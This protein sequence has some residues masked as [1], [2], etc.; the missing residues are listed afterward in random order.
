MSTQ[1][2]GPMVRRMVKEPTFSRKQERNLSVPLRTAR[3]PRASGS[4]PTVPSSRAISA[5]INPRELAP[6]TLP[7]ETRFKVATVNLSALM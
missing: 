3:S 5:L 6:G 7:M 2:T 1:A 4:T